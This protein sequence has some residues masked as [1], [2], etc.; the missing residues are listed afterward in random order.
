VNAVVEVFL[1]DQYTSVR[2]TQ[3]LLYNRF[4]II[5]SNRKNIVSTQSD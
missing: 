5:I 1:V 3:L 2:F 4:V